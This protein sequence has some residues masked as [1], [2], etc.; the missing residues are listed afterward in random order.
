MLPLRRYATLTAGS[1]Q[2]RCGQEAPGP[3]KSSSPLLN[4][5]HVRIRW[6]GFSLVSGLCNCKVLA[7]FS[8]LELST[9]AEQAGDGTLGEDMSTSIKLRIKTL[10]G[11]EH[12]I[13]GVA[14]NVRAALVTGCNT[15][16][17]PVQGYQGNKA[18]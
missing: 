1:T 16:L 2:D 11:E 14:L 8:V 6:A 9:M 18:L 4:S 17:V 10:T 13:T 12:T 5:L 3:A 7:S 15:D